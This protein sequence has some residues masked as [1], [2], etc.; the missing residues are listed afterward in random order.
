MVR[1]CMYRDPTWR[2][3]FPRGRSSNRDP[4]PITK[5]FVGPVERPCRN[6]LAFFHGGLY[7]RENQEKHS[8]SLI[9]SRHRGSPYNLQTT[10]IARVFQFYCSL[11]AQG[12][13]AQ[14]NLLSAILSIFTRL[15]ARICCCFSL[16]SPFFM[17]LTHGKYYA[18]ERDGT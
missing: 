14:G 10:A 15:D 8:L 2:R 18:K 1:E 3:P 12:H 13:R 7:H 11:P 5:T 16:L 9:G 17:Y 6:G 4:L